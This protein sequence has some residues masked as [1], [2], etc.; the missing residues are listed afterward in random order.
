MSTRHLPDYMKR[1]IDPV[2]ER[3]AFFYHPQNM[4]LTTV[5]YERQNMLESGYR[6]IL[7]ARTQNQKVTTV[8]TFKTLSINFDATDHRE[9]MDWT[10]C[11]LPSPP[12]LEDLTTESISSGIFVLNS[13]FCQKKLFYTTKNIVIGC[14]YEIRP[15]M[16]EAIGFV[17]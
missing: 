4:L 10:K 13:F 9:L 1:I 14:S 17:L 16:A 2:I 6:R 5:V 11:R 15:N 3:N 8:R 7:K 12:V